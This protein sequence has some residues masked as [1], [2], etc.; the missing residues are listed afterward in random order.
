MVAVNGENDDDY[1]ELDEPSSSGKT[2]TFWERVG[3][4]WN[5]SCYMTL[6]MAG[7]LR[8]FGGYSLGFLSA[9]FF[10][11]RYPEYTTE[12]SIMNAVIVI[13]GGLPASILGGWLSDKLEGRIGSI[14]GLVSGVGALAAIPFIAIA[15]GW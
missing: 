4:L 13:G 14:K 7:A 3:T 6:V 2:T 10:E 15:Y 12:F 11:D 1:V 8:F 5:N 9:K